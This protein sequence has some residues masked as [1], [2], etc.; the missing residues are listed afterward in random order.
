MMTAGVSTACFY[1]MNTEDALAILAGKGVRAA[2]VFINSDSELEREYLLR[3]R[4]IADAAGMRLLSV[5]PFTSGMEPM[6]FFSDYERRF[7]DGREYYRKYYQAANLLGAEIV[8]FHGNIA[9]WRMETKD[10]CHRFAALMADAKL[11]GVML[12]H[13]NVSRCS[14][15]SPGF[16]KEMSRVLPEARYVLDVKQVIRAGEDVFDFVE[17]MGSHIAHVHI[18]D[19]TAEEDCLSIGKG[20]FHIEEFLSS[21][22]VKGYSGGV[23]VELYRENFL[24]IV[25]LYEGYQQ[26]SRKISTMS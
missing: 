15:R 20:V 7:E 11:E 21:L 17:A 6:L 8:V 22:A 10:Y 26:L 24:D 16:Y 5:H 12:C 1:P 18:S 19:H 23:I 4:K 25:D 13:E 14:G 9:Q 3:L 2:E